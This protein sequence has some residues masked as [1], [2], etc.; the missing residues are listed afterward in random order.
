[1]CEGEWKNVKPLE[2]IQE[3]EK[4]GLSQRLVIFFDVII[5]EMKARIRTAGKALCTAPDD[6]PVYFWPEGNCHP[7]SVDKFCKI[8]CL[9]SHHQSLFFA[10][11]LTVFV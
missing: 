5:R 3:L 4:D 2:Y 10:I 11:K 7:T 9:A 8:M 6:Q 1:M